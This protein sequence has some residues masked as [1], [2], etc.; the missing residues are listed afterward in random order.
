[1]PDDPQAAWQAA[2]DSLQA[3]EDESNEAYDEAKTQAQRDILDALSDPIEAA[4]TALNQEDMESRT[5]A[6]S[7]A[8][9][10]LKAPLAQLSTLKDQLNAVAAGF[11]KAASVVS[12]IDAAVSDL[13][14]YIK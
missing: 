1:M 4:L 9:A 12:A 7:A 6:F 8:A 13:S 11:A 2:H 3:L 5:L 14:S 10:D